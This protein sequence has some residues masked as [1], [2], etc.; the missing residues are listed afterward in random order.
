VVIGYDSTRIPIP[1]LG[2]SEA[3]GTNREHHDDGGYP[4]GQI[5]VFT[6]RNRRKKEDEAITQLLSAAILSN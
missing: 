1:V 6:P 5:G 3:I 2:I 4:A